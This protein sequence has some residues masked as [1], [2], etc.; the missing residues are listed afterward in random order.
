MLYRVHGIRLRYN[1][2]S[3]QNLRT[4]ILQQL[5]INDKDLVF[6]KIIRRSIDARKKPVSIIYSV[7]IEMT[8]SL[9]RKEACL[10]TKKNIEQ[11]IPGKKPGRGI[12]IIVGAGPAG[13]FAGFILAK[14]GYKPIILERGSDVEG[15]NRALDNAKKNCW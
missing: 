3:T 12:P 14:Q 1:R 7:D 6:F 15:R 4:C 5:Q 2:D 13:L 9:L 8:H 10:I 11:I